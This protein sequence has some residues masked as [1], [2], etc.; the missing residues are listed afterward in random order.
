MSKITNFN[1]RV[2]GLL[3]NDKNQIIISTEK[4]EEQTLTKFIGGGLEKGEGLVDCLKR[5]FFEEI[6]L[7]IEVCELYYV[8]DFFQASYFNTNDQIISIY[9]FVKPLNWN[10]LNRK[11]NMNTLNQYLNWVDI[12]NYKTSNL[13]LPIDRVVLEKLKNKT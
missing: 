4:Y 10:D 9:Y 5:E 12:N 13:S 6:K 1:I 8:N 7:K 2:Y 11:I 3:I